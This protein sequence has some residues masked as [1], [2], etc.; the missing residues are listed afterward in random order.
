MQSVTSVVSAS[1]SGGKEN[2]TLC[3]SHQRKRQL[4]SQKKK[5]F[6][7]Y[8]EPSRSPDLVQSLSLPNLLRLLSF[9]LFFSAF[10]IPAHR[11]SDP[12]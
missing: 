3:R 4:L 6:Y 8:Q 1:E 2:A 5:G 7:Y 11:V 12:H 9:S 10:L